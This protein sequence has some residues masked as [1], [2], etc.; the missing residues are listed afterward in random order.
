MLA[1][2][3]NATPIQNTANPDQ[4]FANFT[5]PSGGNFL[6]LIWDYRK[7]NSAELCYSSTSTT[8]A[9]TGC[10]FTPTPVP[11]APV[12]VTPVYRWL[13]EAGSGT[14]TTPTSCP[15][16]SVPLYS[17]ASS[18]A[19]TFTNSTVFYTDAGLTT[20]FQGGNNY[21]GVREP[22]QGYGLSQGIFR[23]TDLG[24]TSNIDTAG[25]CNP[26]PTPV[27]V[28]VPVPSPVA[29]SPA[30]APTVPVPAPSTPTTAFTMTSVNTYWSSYLDAC[31][32]GPSSSTQ[33][34]YHSGSG[35]CPTGGD[36]IYT[37]AAGTTLLSDVISTFGKIWFIPSSVCSPNGK[38]V[39][40]SPGGGYI[41]GEGN[42]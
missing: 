30:P 12:P 29:P 23:M 35:S 5:L 39:E 28:P 33:T 40:I 41:Y 36:Y 17:T 37:D 20:V 3:A 38:A 1:A 21:F 22:N 10:T 26:N 9:C 25:V 8:D 7:S 18:F 15:T 42:C 4:Y 11:T 31:N 19:T 13:I 24:T 32:N 34:Y 16:A 14:A 27:P 2:S 6:Y